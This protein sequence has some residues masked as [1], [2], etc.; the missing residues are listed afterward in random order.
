MDLE[1]VH[2]KTE[3]NRPLFEELTA[4]TG[5]EVN[6]FDSVQDIYNTLI[7]EVSLVLV[8]CSK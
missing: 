3:E 2:R 6:S 5:L 8:V 7:A 1:E 4:I